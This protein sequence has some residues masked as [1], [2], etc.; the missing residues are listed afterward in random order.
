MHFV[1]YMG[2]SIEDCSPTNY[3]TEIASLLTQ[4]P[5]GTSKFVPLLLAK[6]KELLP[7]VVTTL[8]ETIH[9]PTD[10]LNDPMSPDTR[11]VYEDEVG[12]ALYRDLRKIS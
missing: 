9:V 3:L 5:G 2:P 4:L 8:C 1:Y 10:I 12:R 7:E 6:V 11:F